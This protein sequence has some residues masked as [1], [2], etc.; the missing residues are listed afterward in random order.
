MVA[1]ITELNRAKAELRGSEDQ[2]RSLFENS[3]DAVL[4]STPEGIIEAANPEA[5]RMFGRT[6]AE[7]CQ[8]GR[9]GL[10]D[11]TDPRL[12][13]FLEERERL[14]RAQSELTLLRKDGTK[15]L[16][17]VSSAFYKN[18]S[19]VTKASVIIRDNSDRKRAEETLRRITKGTAGSTGEEFFRSLAQNLAHT[20]EVR[21]CFVAE[22]T[23]ETKTRVRTLAFWATDNFAD[24]VEYLLRGTPCESVITGSACAYPD[25]LQE[26]F[27]ED[28]DL[29]ALG[30]QSYAAAPAVNQAGQ[31]LGHLVV[32]DDKPRVF[33]DR[34][35]S[36]LR[37]FATRV[38]GELER[39]RAYKNAQLL[40]LELGVLLDINRAIGRHLN[41]DEL[42]GALAGCLKTLVPTERFGIELPIEGDKLQ[43]HILSNPTGG[44]PTQPTVLPALGTVC[45]WVMENRVWFVATSRDEYHERFPVTFDVMSSQG[46]ESLCALPLVSGDRP[47]GALFFMAAAKGAYGHLRREFLERVAGAVAVALDDC[48]AH[49]EVRSLRDRLAAENVYLQEEIKTEHNFEEIIGQSAPVQRLLRKLGQVAP[50]ETTVLIQ[51]ETGTG[52]ELLARAVHDRSRRKERPLVKVNCG[53][54]PSGLVE[55]ELFGHEKGAFTGATQRRIGRFE[56][57][58]GG[59]IFLD[60]VAE[61]PIDTQVKLLRVLQE[62]E[63]ERVGSSETIKVDVRVIAATNRDPKE[64]VANGTFRSDLFYRLNVFPL[65]VPPLRDRKEDIPLLVNFFL[66]KFGKKLGKELHGVSQKAMENITNYSWPGNVREMQNVVERAVILASGPIVHVDDSMLQSDG[67]VQ[68]SAVDTLENMERNHIIRAL[69][70]TNWVIHGKKGAAESLGINSSTLRSRMDK[71]GIKRHSL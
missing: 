56:L 64:I 30:A 65:E 67:A 49:E 23:D 4:L 16:G 3:N 21:Y 33:G 61:L 9:A 27:P 26:L 53:S 28:K 1:D 8:V 12:A 6:E 22:C 58:H 45:N 57:A 48:L 13:A 51:G 66:S 43:G 38:G 54:I 36:I 70:K 62:G 19:G 39:V 25:R 2:F 10:V 46:M 68:E 52:K 34:E 15:F 71:L 69:N 37:I 31:V 5:C 18:N 40:N 47:R 35:F 41:R 55:S 11:V 20:L 7:I 60:E 50:T 59:T 63:F 14:G 42:F 29:I 24:N 17:E 32:I 44:E